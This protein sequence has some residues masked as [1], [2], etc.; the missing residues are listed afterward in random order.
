MFLFFLA[1]CEGTQKDFLDPHVPDGLCEVRAILGTHCLLNT[2][3]PLKTSLY[4]EL[5]QLDNK[6][7]AKNKAPTL[8]TNLQP[9][10]DRSHYQGAYLYKLFIQLLGI[11]PREK[12]P[13]CELVKHLDGHNPEFVKTSEITLHLYEGA[14]ID[15]KASSAPEI[16]LLKE[17]RNICADRILLRELERQQPHFIQATSLASKVEDYDRNLN[18]AKKETIQFLAEFIDK[19]PLRLIIRKT[20]DRD[21]SS[22]GQDIETGDVSGFH[23]VWEIYTYN[24]EILAKINNDLSG[25]SDI[26]AYAKSV[27]TGEKI[28]PPEV[29]SHWTILFGNGLLPKKGLKEQTSAI[30]TAVIA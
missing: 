15:I 8:L 12:H 22:G 26:R 10:S 14:S 4:K 25:S 13:L 3:D 28:I 17:I 29:M 9:Q 7:F 21:L 16:E 1:I 23:P 5:E 24:D 2:E 6:R 20:N 19:L 18:R 27:F 30:M 11:S